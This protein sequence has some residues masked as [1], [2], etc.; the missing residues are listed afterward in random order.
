MNPI[1]PV[2]YLSFQGTLFP[3]A[4]KLIRQRFEQSPL[5]TLGFKLHFSPCCLKNTPIDLKKIGAHCRV[6]TVYVALLKESK[7]IGSEFAEVQR[8]ELA[9]VFSEIGVTPTVV[10]PAA[11]HVPAEL[12]RVLNQYGCEPHTLNASHDESWIIEH[13]ESQLL[14]ASTL[15]APP[16]TQ[17]PLGGMALHQQMQAHHTHS[18]IQHKLLAQTPDDAANRQGQFADLQSNREWGL[19]NLIAEN[20]VGAETNLRRCLKLFDAD[21]MANYWLCRLLDRN[22]KKDGEYQELIRRAAVL[23]RLI[24]LDSE[25]DH[26]LSVELKQLQANAYLGLRNPSAALALLEEAAKVRPSPQLWEALV[27]AGLQSLSQSEQPLQRSDPTLIRCKRALLQ[28]SSY[29]IETFQAALIRLNRQVAKDKLE[30]I[31]LGIRHDLVA[32]LKSVKQHEHTLLTTATDWELIVPGQSATLEQSTVL[33]KSLWSQVSIAQESGHQQL[34]LL[35]VLAENLL[36]Q[37]NEAEQLS[38]QQARYMAQSEELDAW[39]TRAQTEFTKLSRKQKNQRILTLL[40]AIMA[41]VS[42]SGFWWLPINNTVNAAIFGGFVIITALFAHGWQ[43]ASSLLTQLHS[44]CIEQDKHHQLEEDELPEPRTF[45]GWFDRLTVR[46]DKLNAAV[47][48]TES[49]LKRS[50]LQ[51]QARTGE[52]L[53][54][55]SRFEGLL[56]THYPGLLHDWHSHSDIWVRSVD[57]EQLPLPEILHCYSAEPF[58]S[59]IFGLTGRTTGQRSTPY[60]DLPIDAERMRRLHPIKR[61]AAN[62]IERAIENVMS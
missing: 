48:R 22:A 38:Q 39:K 5:A 57:A 29:G 12:G 61:K 56:L 51:L 58:K 43:S 21:F 50:Q 53:M 17:L 27:L 10:V 59:G 32:H 54:L 6:A 8:V 4:E 2:I 1:N 49:A 7:Q 47:K 9:S 42:L 11:S 35:Q 23:L 13:L 31:L 44:E 18:A 55:T 26:S 28:L 46:R 37:Q 33:G 45:N 30:L 34:T 16:E 60:F 62:M 36:K 24:K 41:L 19:Q 14:N 20:Y 52:F 3:H 40:M 25:S 15:T